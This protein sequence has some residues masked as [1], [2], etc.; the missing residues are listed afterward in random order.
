M[1]LLKAL[2]AFTTQ[3]T[4]SICTNWITIERYF[5]RGLYVTYCECQAICNGICSKLTTSVC[6]QLILH[7]PFLYVSET[8]LVRYCDC[9]CSCTVT[10][11]GQQQSHYW[12]QI[13][14]MFLFNIWLVRRHYSKWRVRCREITRHLQ[15]YVVV[16]CAGLLWSQQ[17]FEW[18]WSVPLSSA[19]LY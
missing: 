19:S 12:I 9:R 14:S 13:K 5:K 18:L 7:G 17:D 3:T 16:R 10:V 4:G 2:S 8:E 1:C 6:C 11:L 15:S